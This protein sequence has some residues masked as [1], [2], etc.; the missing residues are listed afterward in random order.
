MVRT[1]PAFSHQ[2]LHI[3]AYLSQIEKIYHSVP[4][5]DQPESEEDEKPLASTSTPARS[6]AGTHAAMPAS[7]PAVPLYRPNGTGT[8]PKPKAKPKAKPSVARIDEDGD[9]SDEAFARALQAELDGLDG[10][11]KRRTRDVKSK[12]TVSR[13]K[14]RKSAAILSDGESG[15]DTKRRRSGGNNAFMKEM[16][17]E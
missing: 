16:L 7:S 9:D 3:D 4:L 17:L 15:D 1:S 6:S 2:G 11:R 8:T 10:G 14:K 13:V 12:S 5:T